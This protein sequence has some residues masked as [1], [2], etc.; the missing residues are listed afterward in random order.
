[1]AEENWERKVLE[2]LA[3]DILVERRRA[4]RWNIF[5]RLS[6]LA[7]VTFVAVSLVALVGL[8]GKVCLDQCTAVIY[9]DGEIERSGRANAESVIEGLK[10]AFELPQVKGVVVAINSPGGSPVQAGQIHDEMRRL[11]AKYPDKPT[12]A[13]VEELAASGG[14]YIAVGADRIY[15]DKASIVGSIG[16]IMEGFGLAEAIDKLGIE[17]RVIAAGENKSFL[18][19][20]EP[21]DPQHV[22]HIRTM[23]REV[24]EQFITA[25]RNGRGA[26]LKETPDLFSGLV[27]TGQR[28]IELGLADEIG[29]VDYVAREVI[30]AQEIVDFTPE[31]R[32]TDRIARRFGTTIAR[33]V[34][35]EL[36]V[37]RFG[38]Y[39]LR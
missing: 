5:F 11:R 7:I 28:A 29:S 23:L 33:L 34:R 25:V 27:W 6:G 2:R 26:R 39:A 30:K 20:F 24:H 16:V 22:A 36:S 13:V 10:Q 4:R 9:V 17:R 15:V 18:D 38:G 8:G 35:T 32:L 19:P 3:E 14:Y 12:Y 1:M 21:L 37:P 31:E